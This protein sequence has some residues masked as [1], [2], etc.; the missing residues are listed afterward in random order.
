MGRV[1]EAMRRAAEAAAPL[2]L[3]RA[4]DGSATP[5]TGQDLD[6]L[7][8][9]P[10]PT[11]APE[12]PRLRSVTAVPQIGAAAT[13]ARGALFPP[14]TERLDA[15]LSRKVV[16]DH[17]MDPASREQYRRLAA[18]L[19]ATQAVRPLKVV[20]MASAVASEGKSLTS[21]N[22]ALTFSESYQRNV[23][24]ID[25]D[26]RRPSLHTI[27]GLDSSPG[28]CE[29]LMAPD[30]RRLPLHRVTS[31]LTVLTAGTPTSDPMSALSSERMRRLVEEARETFDWVLIDTPPIG[32]LSDASL[33]SQIADGAILVV[34]AGAT[35]F[36]LVQ[37]AIATLGR[38]R[39][40][41][42]VLNQA[43]RTSSAGYKYQDY[44]QAAQPGPPSRD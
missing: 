1:D 18:T 39:L 3:D 10:Y 25:G 8:A 17:D 4:V 26:L 2:N 31:R 24:L 21:S 28:L 29:G 6:A 12:R 44:Y 13:P 34:K 15:R 11:E 43:E 27:F 37:R 20:M 30:D 16:V 7:L 42:V 35:P 41:G 32:L 9:E 19:H 14:L 5:A 33:L 22:L 38:E 40:L 36:D 23:L